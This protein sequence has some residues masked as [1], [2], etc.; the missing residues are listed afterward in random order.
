MVRNYRSDDAGQLTDLHD[1]RRGDI[2]YRYDPLGRLLG[3]SSQYKEEAFAFD[4]ASNLLDPRHRAG[5]ST[6]RRPSSS[7][8]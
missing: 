6:T 4:P 3:A 7:T 8:T 5:P 1:N 2:N